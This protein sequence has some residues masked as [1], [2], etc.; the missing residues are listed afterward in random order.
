MEN[1]D[2]LLKPIHE[3]DGISY[4][5]IKYQ[6]LY[7]VA[8][9]NGN[10]NAAMIVLFLYQLVKVFEYY[11]H[12]LEEESVRD[13]FVIIYELLDEMMDFGYPQATE[14]QFLKD[15]ILQEGERLQKQSP[16]LPEP[17]LPYCTRYQP[18]VYDKNEVF[19]D[20]VE[21]YHFE[22]KA[23]GTVLRSEINGN[24]NMKCHLSGIP[25]L[26]LGL[27]DRI[28][29]DKSANRNRSHSVELNDFQFH[30]CVRLSRFFH[31][32]IIT[33][34]PMDEDFELMRYRLDTQ[35]KP[36][37]WVESVVE[38]HSR[39]R[40]EYSIKMR[41]QFRANLMANN[42]KIIIPVPS[43]ASNPSF[44][45]NIGR[46]VYQPQ[47][48][49]IVWQIKKFAG[50][51]ETLMRAHLNLPSIASEER[52]RKSPISVQFELPHYTISGARILYLKILE[53]SGYNAV[54][55][56]RYITKSGDYHIGM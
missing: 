12:S 11:F 49:S 7:L 10:G 45:A 21:T 31:D 4:V 8:V 40:V 34:I 43:D 29:F 2:S 35:I 56:V 26:R 30:Q 16:L 23:N 15:Y 28:H 19:V 47:N 3:E 39:S 48:N 17:T 27:N 18:K 25:E 14:P 32:G 6:D 46:V 53:R 52:Q 9:T 24:I 55:W 36:P 41:S 38:Q 33:F 50:G 13:N 42:I 5:H 37:I 20:V 22:M 1:E 54:P 51:K 44:Q